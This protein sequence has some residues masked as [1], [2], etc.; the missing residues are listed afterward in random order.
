MQSFTKA[1]LREAS[2]TLPRERYASL[3][4]FEHERERIF[5]RCWTCLAR[6]EDVAEPGD[7][8]LASLAGENLIVVRGRDGVVRAL[9][10][11]CRHRGTRLC[12]EPAGHF[13]GAIQCPYH[14][15]TYGVDGTLLAAR[16]MADVAG[17]DRDDYPLH[18]A[19]VALWGGFVFVSLAAEPEPFGSALAALDGRYDPW[20]LASLRTAHTI[21]YD[22]ACN[23]KLVFQN[24]SECYHCPVIHPQLE[25]LSASDS[26]R[27]DLH[28]GAVLGGYST[29]R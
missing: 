3:E 16:N 14:A 23:W 21:S 9:Y 2:K 7:Y 11:V 10:N 24:Y 17:F 4:N 28:E 18:R 29:L 19:A 15:W 1:R 22:V 20:T 27:N 13:T 26:G 5:A 8:V 12:D 6:E 25:E